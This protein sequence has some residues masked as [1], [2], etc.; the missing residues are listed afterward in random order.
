MASQRKQNHFKEARKTGGEKTLLDT[1]A[2]IEFF[3]GTEKGRE[4]KQAIESQTAYT[5]IITIA[6]TTNWALKQAQNHNEL[7]RKIKELSIIL[8]INEETSKLAGEINF[9]RKKTIKKLGMMDS[10][11]LATALQYNQQ[12]LTTDYD[13]KNIANVKII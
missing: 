11:I 8:D 3:R 4:V 6:E 9:K 13:F 10:I 1:S 2:W 7:I 12:I 5:S